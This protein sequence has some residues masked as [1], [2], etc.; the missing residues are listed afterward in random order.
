MDVHA[1]TVEDV[2]GT[3]AL[4][5]E[6]Y[7]TAE[8]RA[9]GKPWSVLCERQPLD[10][11]SWK[12]GLI[13]NTQL[14]Y[15]CRTFFTMKGKEVRLIDP[16]QRYAFLGIHNFRKMTRHDWKKAVARKVTELLQ[17]N[18]SSRAEHELNSFGGKDFDMC[19]SLMDDLSYY[20]RSW[21]AL[22]D[23]N[24]VDNTTPGETVRTP[25]PSAGPKTRRTAS[26]GNSS[27]PT[28]T[29]RVKAAPCNHS[30]LTLRSN[31]MIWSEAGKLQSILQLWLHF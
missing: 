15:V 17:T 11:Q 27:P 6:I 18:F 4:L 25:G 26:N 30:S 22:L 28:T 24:V 7:D 14:E 2:S 23:G 10:D 9:G 3:V 20:Y 13:F 29:A 8:V 12:K 1:K 19:D 16:S 31:I 21:G 5:Q